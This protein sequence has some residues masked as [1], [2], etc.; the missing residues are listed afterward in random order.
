MNTSPTREE[1]RLAYLL[2]LGR[3]PESEA[4]VDAHRAAHRDLASVRDAFV[5]SREFRERHQTAIR[6]EQGF[7]PRLAQGYFAPHLPVEVHVAPPV[8]ERLAARIRDQWTKL[9][10][11]DPFWS[12]LTSEEYRVDRID[13]AA[14]RRFNKSGQSAAQLIDLTATRT[15][16]TPPT[17]TC[18][19]LGCGVGRI[20][21]HL[22][23]RFGRVIAVDISPG[24]LALCERYLAEEG[25]HNVETR[26][27]RAID[28]LSTL[29]T[30]DFFYSMIVL[31]HN[32]PPIQFRILQIL[33]EKI[34]RGG[35][36]L[37]Q[38]VADLPGYSFNVES[39]LSS[40]SPTMEVHSLP[41]PTVLQVIRESGL[42]LDT[43][44]MDNWVGN[45]G[46]YTFSAHREG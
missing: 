32:P 44:R 33:L 40:P 26:L 10:E 12:V 14:R 1:V 31:Q 29:P 16:L 20:T 28:E 35:Q 18:I 41:M 37:F 19:E 46:S 5:A 25:V 39:Y 34:G 15:G 11:S 24:N 43:A 4:V 27:I 7:L 36:C 9:G 45:Y 30:V 38:T 2:L 42:I 17:G 6:P 8:A 23:N 21:R 3:E 13:A 22:A